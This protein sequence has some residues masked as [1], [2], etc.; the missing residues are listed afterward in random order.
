MPR[1]LGEK[2]LS[3]GLNSVS[4]KKIFSSPNPP[5]IREHDLTREK[6]L[7]RYNQGKMRSNTGLGWAKIV[8]MREK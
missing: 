5:R 3:R 4:P 2:Y 6:G 8:L 1:V 7:C